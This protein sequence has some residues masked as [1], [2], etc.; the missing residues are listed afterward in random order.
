MILRIDFVD[1]GIAA[2]VGIGC[3]GGI[4]GLTV[5]LEWLEKKWN[6]RHD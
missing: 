3:I 2:L 4:V 6:D 5:F 1:A